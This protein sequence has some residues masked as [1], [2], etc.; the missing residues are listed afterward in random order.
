MTIV[1]MNSSLNS[2][3]E[4]VVT[5]HVTEPF[6]AYYTDKENGKTCSGLKVESIYVGTYDCDELDIGM[7]IEILYD[8]AV[9]TKRGTFQPIKRIEMF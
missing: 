3:G 4:K 2:K 9:T 1:G 5:L 7:E 6:D 8:K